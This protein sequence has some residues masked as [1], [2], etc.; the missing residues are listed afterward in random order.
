MKKKE[1]GGKPTE[2]T[3]DIF[4]FCRHEFDELPIYLV[5]LD[6]KSLNCTSLSNFIFYTYA[7][8]S[9]M[10]VKYENFRLMLKCFMYV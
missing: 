10:N 6:E 9:I 4:F 2:S 8:L 5:K 1:N 7:F 3:S